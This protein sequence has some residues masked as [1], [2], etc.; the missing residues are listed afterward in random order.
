MTSLDINGIG[1]SQKST[2]P[3]ALFLAAD[4]A[5]D[6]EGAECRCCVSRQQDEKLGDVQLEP[7]SQIQSEILIT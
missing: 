2:I 5:C 7:F 6:T 3:A 1:M 4:A